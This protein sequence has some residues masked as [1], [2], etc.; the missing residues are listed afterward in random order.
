MK[1]L[2]L[3][4]L[5][6]VVGCSNTGVVLSCEQLPARPMVDKWG[7]EKWVCRGNSRKEVY[8]ADP[9]T[10]VEACCNDS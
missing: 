10:L 9:S 4:T 5:M 1:L 6:S 2:T 7:N 8:T 3:L